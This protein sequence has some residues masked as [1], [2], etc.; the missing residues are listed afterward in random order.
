MYFSPKNLIFDFLYLG[1]KKSIVTLL[2]NRKRKT[3]KKRKGKDGNTTTCSEQKID[4]R[5]A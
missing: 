1:M 3:K 2:R 4:D 5:S